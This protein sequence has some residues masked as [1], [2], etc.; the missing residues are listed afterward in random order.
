MRDQFK[1]NLLSVNAEEPLVTLLEIYHPNFPERIYV[2]DGVEEIQVWG[3]TW[4]GCPFEYQLPNSEDQVVSAGTISIDN[5]GGVLIDDGQG[6]SKTLSQWIDDADGGR[7]VR[8]RLVQ[9]LL[10]DPYPE[11]DIDFQLSGLSA[12]RFKVSGQISHGSTAH[13][14]NAVGLFFTPE[15]APG[16]F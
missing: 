8:I 11:V 9:T 6:N 3:K 12:D 15:T 14:N 5:V 16:I 10:S 13:Q 7:N 1:E 4:L 2:H